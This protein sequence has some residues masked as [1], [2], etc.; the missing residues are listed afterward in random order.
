MKMPKDATLLN[1][2]CPENVHEAEMLEVLSARTNFC[3]VSDAPSK[4]AEEDKALA[5]DRLMKRVG[6]TMKKM[7]AQTLDA[8]C[9]PVSSSVCAIKNGPAGEPVRSRR[10]SPSQVL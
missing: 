1:T 4:S 9:T 7:G 8:R 5:G 3:H 6:F 10:S 2:A